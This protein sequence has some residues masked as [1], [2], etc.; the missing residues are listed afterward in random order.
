M[1]MVAILVMWPGATEQTFILLLSGGCIWNQIEIGPAVLEKIS[2]EMVVD[3][4]SKWPWAKVAE[5]PWIDLKHSYSA[6][7]YLLSCEGP[8]YFSKNALF[9]HFP[10]QKPKEPNLTLS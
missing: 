9:Y 8:Q 10:I 6:I 7:L 3:L 5:W 1:G 4:H 2:F